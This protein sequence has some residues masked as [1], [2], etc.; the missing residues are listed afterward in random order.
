MLNF[1][2]RLL[3]GSGYDTSGLREACESVRP[4]HSFGHAHNTVAQIAGNHGL[5]GLI[6]LLALT[7]SILR[8]LW[9]QRR[10]ESTPRWSPWGTTSWF[11]I[12]LALNL[13][14]VFCALSTTVQEFSPVNQLL[15]GLVAEQPALIRHPDI[16]EN[17]RCPSLSCVCAH[18]LPGGRGG[19]NHRGR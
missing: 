9:R 10:T 5:L 2:E 13:A 4:G 12:S 7:G 17:Q 11:E 18:P 3:M 15:I 1:S 6:V 19:R 14:L 16:T 8:G